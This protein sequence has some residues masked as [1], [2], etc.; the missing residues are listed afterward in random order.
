METQK[1]KIKAIISKDE[2]RISLERIMKRYHSLIGGTLFVV[3]I[4]LRLVTIDRPGLMWKIIGDLGTFLAASVAIPF[5]YQ[6]FIKTEDRRLFLMDLE[7][8]LEAKLANLGYGKSPRFYESGRLPLDQKLAFL[9]DAK[10]EVIEVGIALRTLIGYFEQRPYPEFKE[11]IRK[12]LKDGVNFKFLLLNPDSEI[13]RKYAE[14]RKEPDLLENIRRSIRILCRLKD[15]F[16]AAGLPG[17]FEIFVYSHFPS[18]YVMLVDP[19]EGEGRML[20]SHYLYATKRADAPVIEVRK[21]SNPIL[22]EKY[23]KFVKTLLDDSKA[24]S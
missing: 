15:E 18:C 24:I 11:P 22:F 21:S 3:G 2:L 13:A 9:R 8:L 16:K 17:A 14:D 10:Y 5:I 20:I 19:M 7:E 1:E 6:V 4:S 23:Y 12:L